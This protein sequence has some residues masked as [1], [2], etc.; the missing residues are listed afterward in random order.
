MAQDDFHSVLSNVRLAN[1]IVW[2]LP[3][4]LDVS[5]E[6][7]DELRVGEV[8][9]LTDDHDEVMALLHLDEEYRF[10]KEEMARKLYGTT[11]GDH[12]GLRMISQM[13]PIL[14]AGQIDL[15]KKRKSETRAYEL[16]PKQVRRLFEERGWAKVVGFHTRNVIHRAHEFMQLTAMQE[17]NCDGLFVHPV[18]GK[19]K[20]GDFNSTYIIKSYEK[21]IERFYPRNRVVLATLSTF[22]RYAGPREALFTALCRK[23]FGCSHFIVGRDHTGVGNYYDPHASHRI[24]DK[25]PDLGIKAVKFDEVF[26]SKKLGRYVHQ[27]SSACQHE[28]N[29]RLRLSGTQARE[30]FEKGEMPPDWFMRPEVSRIILDAIESGEQVFVKSDQM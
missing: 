23:N 24:F 6:T 28:E 2:P 29:E 27:K 5:Q 21:M 8:V 3:I 11:V 30:M 15:I 9:G 1:G 13:K 19:K 17:E 20:A 14:L 16:T 12:P 25:F 18:I 7:A 4:V 26:Y 22:S 10:D